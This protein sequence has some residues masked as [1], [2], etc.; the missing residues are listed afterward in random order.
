MSQATTHQGLQP[1]FTAN[2]G[3]SLSVSRIFLSVSTV[4]YTIYLACVSNVGDII[5]SGLLFAAI[6]SSIAPWYSMGPAR[7]IDDILAA[8]PYMFFWLLSNLFL[9]CLHNQ[10]Q[11]KT[12]AEDKLNK[13]WRPIPAGRLTPG[14][15]TKI[16]YLMHLI[17]FFIAWYIGGFIPYIV[18]TSLTLGYNELDGASNGISKNIHTGVGFICFFTGPLEVATEHSVITGNTELRIWLALLTAAIATTCHIQDFRDM[19]GD[20]A[21]GRRTIPL[22]FGNIQSRILVAVTI[23]MWTPTASLLWGGL[24]KE[25]ALAYIAGAAVI[26]NLFLNRGTEGDIFSW[27]L[28]SI[29]VLGLVIIPFLKARADHGTSVP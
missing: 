14:Q 22:A 2:T 3:A 7:S 27:K 20:L 21:A 16:L 11:P 23:A 8:L 17:C 12:I 29:W 13:P 1:T 10:K 9:F 19:K 25:A 4:L 5:L 6:N 24:L 26:G 15:A 18:L 28:W